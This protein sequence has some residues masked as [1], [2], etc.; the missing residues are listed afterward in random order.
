MLATRLLPWVIRTSTIACVA[1]I[2]PILVQTIPSTFAVFNN[3]TQQFRNISEVALRR[4]MEQHQVVKDVIDTVPLHVAEV[5]FN[6]GVEMKLGNELTPTQVQNVPVSVKWPAEPDTLY[7]VCMTDPD[8][9]S[10]QQP[11]YRE[12]HHWLVVNV[13]GNDIGKGE[14]LS[15]YVGSGPPKGTGLHRYVLVIYKQPG[16]ITPDEKRLTNRSGEGRANFKIR[17]FAKKYNLGEPVAGN[18]YQAEWDDY[19]PKLYEQLSGE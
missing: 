16:K 2:S 4:T 12:W 11:K 7:T 18:F 6:S 1:K 15:E 8:A 17:E 10:R 14:I 3:Q 19:V 9:P 5:K 13:P